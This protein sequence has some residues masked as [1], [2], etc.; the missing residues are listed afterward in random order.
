L[1]KIFALLLLNL[2]FAILNVE[3]ENSPN[4]SSLK[5]WNQLIHAISGDVWHITVVTSEQVEYFGYLGFDLRN[6][7]GELL[8]TCN[9]QRLDNYVENPFSLLLDLLRTWVESISD[10]DLELL[11][12]ILLSYFDILSRS[13]EVINIFRHKLVFESL[14]GIFVSCRRLPSLFKDLLFDGSLL[15]ELFLLD[16]STVNLL[17]I[18]IVNG[19]SNL[20]EFSWSTLVLVDELKIFIV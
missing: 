7:L 6:L 9:G 14:M 19:P 2:E 17:I 18:R 20:F 11:W 15:V 3:V 4:I 13:K 1:E 10:F 12:N 5:F 16:G 8:I